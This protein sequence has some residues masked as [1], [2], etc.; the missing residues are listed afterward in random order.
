MDEYKAENAKSQLKGVSDLDADQEIDK[1][2]NR[3]SR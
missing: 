2:R 1:L 3:K